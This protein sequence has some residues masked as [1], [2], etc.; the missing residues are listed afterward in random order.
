[1]TGSEHDLPDDDARGS[2]S[3]A[4]PRDDDA[5]WAEIV[6][7][8]GER[9]LPPRAPQPQDLHPTATPEP[10]PAA[11]APASE[12]TDRD[13]VSL[14]D[15]SAYAD[16][17][18]VEIREARAEAAERFVPP[19]LEPLPRPTPLRAAAWV[20]ALGVPLFVLIGAIVSLAVPTIVYGML[21]GWF[22]VGFVYLV[23][24]MSRQPRDPWDDGSRV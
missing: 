3:A 22:V 16:P 12:E 8:Y 10:P 21:I 1:M 11:P 18:P 6:A 5:A 7:N 13:E 2:D 4:H 19:P 14:P 23:A 9:V 15:A 20:G 24:T 17:D